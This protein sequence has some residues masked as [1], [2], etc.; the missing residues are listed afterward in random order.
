METFQAKSNKAMKSF[1]VLIFSCFVFIIYLGSCNDKGK[2]SYEGCD[3]TAAGN[4][5]STSP[6]TTH[7]ISVSGASFSDILDDV[8][9]DE[10]HDVEVCNTH[11]PSGRDAGD[12]IDAAIYEINRQFGSSL[13]FNLIRSGVSHVSGTGLYQAPIASRFDYIDVSETL[14]TECGTDTDLSFA[15]R[16]CAWDQSLGK[17]DHFA[18]MC[19]SSNYS[20]FSSSTSSD[21]PMQA[22]IM[23]EFAHAFGMDH[24]SSWD[25]S[26]SVN[27]ISTMQGDLKYLS[28]LD[29]EFLRRYY[30]ASTSCHCNFVAS[31]LTR[32]N[33]VKGKFDDQNPD[34]FDIDGSGNLTDHSTSNDPW[35]YVAWFNTGNQAAES[36][37]CGYNRIYLRQ[38]AD[39]GEEIEIYTW[40]IATMHAISQDQWKDD[41]S[42]TVPDPT[43]IDKTAD[44]ELVFR[45]NYG[46]N[47][48]ESTDEDN[49]MTK[50]VILN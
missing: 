5:C 28:A 22:N 30:S 3:D 20:H 16:T 35:F 11:F 33:G 46:D 21:H 43:S 26:D 50:P 25:A 17:T 45:V 1:F 32:F 49:E 37:V 7:L 8:L 23:H 29:V 41:V 4:A 44:W 40:P 48:S 9:R 24:T 47:L 38:V 14:P 39:H 6:S 19:K 27:F 2:G 10:T 34:E 12:E 15:M 36:D 18:I 31:S 42:V 13:D